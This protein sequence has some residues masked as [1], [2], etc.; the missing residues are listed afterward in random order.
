MCFIHQTFRTNKST[1][2]SVFSDFDQV[3]HSDFEFVARHG[4]DDHRI[5]LSRQLP[6]VLLISV[7]QTLTQS[8]LLSIFGIDTSRCDII[9]H[10]LTF[11]QSILLA[12]LGAS[13]C[14]QTDTTSNKQYMTGIPAEKIHIHQ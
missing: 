6:H 8:C 11:I 10:E 5:K 9:Y 12:N 13:F 3:L 1:Y 2:V 14:G 7:H 4:G